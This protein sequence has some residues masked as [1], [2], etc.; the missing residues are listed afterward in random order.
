MVDVGPL[1][2]QA[3]GLATVTA[4]AGVGQVVVTRPMVPAV[5]ETTF[6]VT[7]DAAVQDVLV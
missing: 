4:A 5:Q 2:T 6:V 7:L 1:A 3:V